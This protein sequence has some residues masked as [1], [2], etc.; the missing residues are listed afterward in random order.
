MSVVN[1]SEISLIG[2]GANITNVN[3]ANI[4]LT[5]FGKTISDVKVSSLSVTVWGKRPPK[6]SST[7]LRH[8]RGSRK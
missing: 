7:N 4:T 6:T 1:T 3:V 2:Y 5:S 8:S